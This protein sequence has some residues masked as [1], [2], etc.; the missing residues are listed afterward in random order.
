MLPLD[1][2]ASKGWHEEPATPQLSV[3]AAQLAAVA[4]QNGNRFPCAV[5]QEAHSCPASP[6]ELQHL[7]AMPSRWQKSSAKM[8][9]WK[10][11]RATSSGRP[12]Q[13]PSP[14]GLGMSV[15]RP[16]LPQTQGT[17]CE[18]GTV[19]STNLV[20]DDV[21]KHVPAGRVLHRDRQVPRP[22]EQLP[23]AH[24]VGSARPAAG[25]SAPLAPRPA[26]SP[27]PAPGT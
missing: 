13:A 6:V 16:Q 17:K 24:Y 18:W 7:L 9:C 20:L 8:S 22:Q 19:P 23:E 5:H 25:G 11:C 21:L 26:Q 4:A 15:L 14:A 10:K 1:V 3:E 2:S 12:P 27:R